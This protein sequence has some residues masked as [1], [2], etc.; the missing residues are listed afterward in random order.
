[1]GEQPLPIA[2]AERVAGKQV[3]AIE[4]KNLCKNFGSFQAV[5]HLTL[6]VRQGESMPLSRPCSTAPLTSSDATCWWLCCWERCR[7]VEGSRHELGRRPRSKAT[8]TAD[9]RESTLSLV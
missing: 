4:M 5:D 2:T 3:P 1:M 6:T 7:C 9:E 8:A